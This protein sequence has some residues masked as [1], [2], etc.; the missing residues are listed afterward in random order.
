[1]GEIEAGQWLS[2]T[3]L[4]DPVCSETYDGRVVKDTSI[5]I[6]RRSQLRTLSDA[7]AGYRLAAYLAPAGRRTGRSATIGT[8]PASGRPPL[9]PVVDAPVATAAPEHL[10]GL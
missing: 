6:S 9:T 1:I 2:A 5:E 7:E 8:A 10:P 4:V 3:G